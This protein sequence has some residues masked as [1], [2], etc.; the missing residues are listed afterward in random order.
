MLPYISI[1]FI[2]KD[3]IYPFISFKI[4]SVL[5][6]PL[7]PYNYTSHASEQSKAPEELGA[8][9]AKGFTIL[10]ISPSTKKINKGFTTWLNWVQI[11]R[12]RILCVCIYIY[13]YL[14]T[15]F[16]F[17]EV[18]K[19]AFFPCPPFGIKVKVVTQLL[20]HAGTEG[21]VA[22]NLS[23]HVGENLGGSSCR[24]VFITNNIITM[25]WK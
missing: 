7:S 2:Y 11:F 5:F 13:T 23:S 14:G 19:L 24:L 18:W 10:K 12:S 9:V 22:T 25:F 17:F 20:I 21:C 3:C 6:L 8:L 16:C 15:L 4:P 1:Y